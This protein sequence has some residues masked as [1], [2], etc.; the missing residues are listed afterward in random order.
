MINHMKRFFK[1]IS[2]LAF[3]FLTFH[4]SDAQVSVNSDQSPPHPSAGLDI[5]SST[6][7]FLPPRMSRLVM[8]SIPSPADGLLV[9]CTDCGNGS[10]GALCICMGGDWRILAADCLTPEEP[11]AGTH[12]VSE[13][14][15]RWNWNKVPGAAGYKLHLENDYASAYDVGTD[16][17][18]IEYLAC[19]S[20]YTRYLWA[21]AACGPSTAATLNAATPECPFYCGESFIDPR[22]DKSYQ[23]I[24]IGD[25]CWMRDNLN[26]GTRING[27]QNQTNNSAMEKYCY[28]DLTSNCDIYGGLYQWAEAVQYLNG[29][30]NTASWNPVPEGNIRGL[31]PEGWHI[32]TDA[33]WTALTDGLGGETVA[34]GHMKETGTTHWSSPNTDA[35]NSSWFTALPGGIRT[36]AGAFGNLNTYGYFLSSSEYTP[37]DYYYR[38]LSYNTADVTRNYAGKNNAESIRCVQD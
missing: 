3:L 33:E 30:S 36:Y 37:G 32:P 2:V 4:F 31:C 34:G 10:P 12:S 38:R 14:Y 17:T 18:Y 28:N 11:A 35:T 19:D 25:K 24:Q 5:K 1:A 15:V 16:T 7:G 9:F 20:T 29:A 6:R 8:L 21:Y 22:D 27:S 23:T 26:I 13:Y